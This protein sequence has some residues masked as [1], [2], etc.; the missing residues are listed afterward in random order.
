MLADYVEPT[1]TLRGFRRSGITEHAV[2]MYFEAM[3][4]HDCARKHR[5]TAEVPN[6]VIGLFRVH[7]ASS[8]ALAVSGAW[9]DC[10][11]LYD[12]SGQLCNE[13]ND[14]AELCNGAAQQFNKSVLGS[15]PRTTARSCKMSQSSC[16]MR[17]SSCATSQRMV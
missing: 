12:D 3:M 8:C 4:L 7:G 9:N 14:C 13:S 10:A 2:L 1:W 5:K 6:D 15:R 11:Q 16:V 17:R